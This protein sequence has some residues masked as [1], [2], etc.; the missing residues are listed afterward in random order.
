M[1][2]A[3]ILFQCIVIMHCVA[4]VSGAVAILVLL[5]LMVG[6]RPPKVSTECGIVEGVF[7]SATKTFAFR[8]SKHSLRHVISFLTS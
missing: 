8:V 4:V 7:D 3:C 1:L 2:C 6:E 5:F